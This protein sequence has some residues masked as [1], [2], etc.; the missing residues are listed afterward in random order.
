QATTAGG[1]LSLHDALPICDAAG[2]GRLVEAD[3]EEERRGAG[4]TLGGAGV[5]DAGERRAAA[6]T[7][8]G[9]GSA[10][11]RRGRGA[12]EIGGVVVAVDRKSTRLNSS[13]VKSPY[14]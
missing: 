11:A 10:V 2:A 6:A 7:W 9:R 5:A 4:I 8:G 3:G 13:H 12:G 14:A 1:P